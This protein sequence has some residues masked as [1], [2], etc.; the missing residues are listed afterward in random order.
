MSAI[1]HL[2]P[3]VRSSQRSG[4]RRLHS[5]SRRSP[6]YRLRRIVGQ[7]CRLGVPIKPGLI[8]SPVGTE[9]APSQTVN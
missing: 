2:E 5:G 6:I 3:F 7:S 1:G 9:L 4:E 8:Q